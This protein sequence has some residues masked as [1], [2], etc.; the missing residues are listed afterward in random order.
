M[1]QNCYVDLKNRKAYVWDDQMG[2]QTFPYRKYC[3]IKDPNGDHVTMFGDPCR[4]TYSWRDADE[5][6]LF[7]SDVNSITRVLVDLYTDDDTPSVGHTVLTYDIEV[8][9]T[10]GFPD[11]KEAANTITSLAGH[12]SAT[13][14]YT[15]FIL[16]PE[17]QLEAQ[18]TGNMVVLPFDT[19]EDMLVAFINYWNEVSPTIVTGWNTQYFDNPYLINR[20]HNIL[21][22]TYAK[23]LS[24]IGIIDFLDFTQTW[25][26]AGV[27]CLDYLQLYKKFNYSEE[28]SYSL[29]AIS[30]KVLG[31][32]KIEYSGDLD[33]LYK[34]DISKFIEYNMTDVELVVEIDRKLQFIDLVRGIAH[35]GHVCYEDFIY[36]S[37]YLEGAILTY[38]KQHNL[39]ACNKP[40]NRLSMED[41]QKGFDGAYVKIPKG[42]VYE[43][44]YDLDL[45]SLYPSII[46]SLNISP[47]TKVGVIENW[48]ADDFFKGKRD[49]W[50][51]DGELVD[52]KDALAF[53][54]DN[55]IAVSTNGVMYRTDIVGCIP[56]ILNTWFDKRVEYKNLMKKY[57]KAG[58]DEQYKFY[59]KRQLVQKILLNSLYGA[60]GL[61]VF[62]FYD[63]DNAL[64]VTSVGQK[65]IK[66]TAHVANLKYNKEL[67]TTKQDFNIY[68]DTD[69]VYFSSIPIIEH[70]HDTSDWGV[71]DWAKATDELASEMQEYINRFYDVMAK[72]MFNVTSHR[73]EIKKEYVARRALWIS[74]KKRY[75]QWIIRD[76]GVPVD[77][78]DV[79]GMDVVRST[80]PVAFR[81]VMNDVLNAII[82]EDKDQ[83]DVDDIIL[84][85]KRHMGELEPI[86]IARSSSVKNVTKYLGEQGDG[87]RMST[88]IKGTPVHVKASIAYNDLLKYYGCSFEYPPI[89]D[90]D[91]IKW[92]YLKD[93][94]LRLSQL[95]FRGEDDPEEILQYVADHIDVNKIYDRELD[96]K[97]GSIYEALNWI[98]PTATSARARK[99]FTFK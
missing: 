23:R 75:A 46:M 7:E 95:A 73:F 66:S 88:Y 86:A 57:G 35:A 31:R 71:D 1:Y 99:F 62:R 45:T 56:D 5:G 22:S 14:V 19:E 89:R 92:V 16:D 20:I 64:A 78:L 8:D 27:S 2:L 58:D 37:K 69:S 24:P 68:I 96:K 41:R 12:D 11:P 47:E 94:P 59:H 4:K 85:F 87:N 53:V 72:R 60:L 90:G 50:V 83:S 6:D 36:S 81:N 74:A 18:E 25:R 70:R 79:K 34:N 33:S 28:S 49:R 61:P 3:Y 82:L 67:G 80:F 13:D 63:V 9:S 32:G 55:D 97:L 43:W 30:T 93:N 17:E 91:K 65:V 98:K 26:I 52:H 54:K 38:L 21:G 10:D 48:D 15:V 84:N 29:N 40:N 42:G 44:V 39:V 76:N 51:M 77:K